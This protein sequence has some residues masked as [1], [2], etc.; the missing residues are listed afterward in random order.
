[1]RASW[2][3]YGYSPES[4][5]DLFLDVDSCV[6]QLWQ[7]GAAGTEAVIDVGSTVARGNQGAVQWLCWKTGAKCSA[8]TK[9]DGDVACSVVYGSQ[10]SDCF[11]FPYP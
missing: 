11:S 10:D 4:S 1:M 3:I 9:F 5:S 2:K 6:Y 7:A 8:A